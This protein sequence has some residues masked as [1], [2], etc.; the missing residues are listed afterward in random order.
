MKKLLFLLIGLLCICNVYADESNEIVKLNIN[1]EQNVGTNVNETK[2]NIEALYSTDLNNYVNIDDKVLLED[3]KWYRYE[4]LTIDDTCENYEYCNIESNN[5]G[6]LC[7]NEDV[8][9]EDENY[10][11]YIGNISFSEDIIINIVDNGILINNEEKIENLEYE[12]TEN[13]I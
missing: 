11:L 4:E 5:Y 2:I 13:G 9:I 3:V 6:V 10:I 12:N 8:F 7:T 1:F